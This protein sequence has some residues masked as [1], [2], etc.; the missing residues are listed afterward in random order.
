M[1]PVSRKGR[2][3]NSSRHRRGTTR[4]QTGFDGLVEPVPSTT[5]VTTRTSVSGVFDVTADDGNFPAIP[6]PILAIPA[7]GAV[8]S[9]LNSFGFNPATQHI[10]SG[11]AFFLLTDDTLNPF[12][13]GFG[14]DG[15]EMVS[16]DLGAGSFAGPIAV[17]FGTLTGG[18][19][20]GS[21]IIDLNVDGAITY[22]VSSTTGAF[23]FVGARLQVDAIDSPAVA[24][25]EG[26]LTGIL[27]GLGFLATAFARRKS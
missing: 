27:L 6:A 3:V 14:S 22:E 15:V 5:K 2:S 7:V 10:I 13:A 26:G 11:T 16:I 4:P 23:Y 19:I 20:S 9:A 18:A 1:A 17:N 25:P 8:F 21:A 12:D 24:T